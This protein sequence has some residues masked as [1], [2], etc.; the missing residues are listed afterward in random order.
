MTGVDYYRGDQRAGITAPDPANQCE[1]S[2]HIVRARGKR[3]RYT[4]VSLDRHAIERFGEC[5]YLLLRDLLDRDKHTL[6]EHVELMRHLA[7]AARENEKGERLTA[8]QGLR[9]ARLRKEGLVIWNFNID[10]IE[11]KS[12]ITWAYAKVQEY[13]KIC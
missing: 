13:F 6:M 7:E 9:Y 2:E 11:R 10:G 12:L 1:V 4:S 8:I 5:D 3:S